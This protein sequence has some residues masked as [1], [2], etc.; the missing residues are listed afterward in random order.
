MNLFVI[1]IG[2]MHE[3]SLIELHDIRFVVANSIEE[4]YPYLRNSWWG[5]SEGLHLDSWGILK[6]AD[7][8]NISLRPTAYSGIEKLYFVNLGGYDKTK[9]TELHENVFIVASTPEEAKVKAKNLVSHW[10]VPH[11]DNQYEIEHILDVSNII[12]NKDLYIHLEKADKEG[13][14]EFTCKYVPI[15]KEA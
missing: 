10:E 3:K 14:F 13:K 5:R 15:W 1:Y 9:F 6:Y 8:Y 2:G 7:G 11:K 12:D 4:T